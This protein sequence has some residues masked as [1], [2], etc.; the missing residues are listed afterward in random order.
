MVT[1]A[2]RPRQDSEPDRRSSEQQVRTREPHAQLPRPA[3][4]PRP[5]RGGDPRGAPDSG[6]HLGTGPG[7]DALHQLVKT[8]APLSRP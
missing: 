6:G 2:G 3:A 8:A 4:G 1:V 5:G 7:A